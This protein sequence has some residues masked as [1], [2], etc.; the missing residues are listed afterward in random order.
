MTGLLHLVSVLYDR[1]AHPAKTA[2]LG[3]RELERQFRTSG[4]S[5]RSAQKQVSQLSKRPMQDAAR[6]KLS[7]ITASF[8]N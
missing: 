5:K 1:L 3:K 7:T 6:K 2:A 4:M 8:T